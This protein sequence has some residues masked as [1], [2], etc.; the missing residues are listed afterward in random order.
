MSTAAEQNLALIERLVEAMNAGVAMAVI[1]RIEE[2]VSP[3]VVWHGA[4]VTAEAPGGN[5]EY[6]GREGMRRFW[7]DVAD[8]WDDLEVEVVRMEPV[9]DELV[10]ALF[11]ISGTGQASGARVTA[12]IGTV[13]GFDGGLI[14]HG[15]NFMSHAEAEAKARELA[16]ESVDAQA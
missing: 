4:A 2:F 9:G 8:V 14:S 5:V 7:Q 12:D 15:Q 10:L 3:D 11:S 1:P 6:R 13:Y 16:Q